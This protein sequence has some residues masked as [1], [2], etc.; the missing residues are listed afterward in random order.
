MLALERSSG[1]PPA[2]LHPC[3]VHADQE[4][5]FQR[6]M[7]L[8]LEGEPAPFSWPLCSLVGLVERGPASSDAASAAPSLPET[9]A[10]G[11]K[12]R[13]LAIWHSA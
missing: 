2:T 1:H 10:G 9:R 6:L 5:V 3:F 7:W 8:S 11:K 4:P 13:P 12:V